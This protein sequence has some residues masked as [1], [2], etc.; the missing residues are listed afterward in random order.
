MKNS[1]AL[2]FLVLSL[3][4]F[5][6]F[7]A[8]VQDSGDTVNRRGTVADDYYAAGGTIVVDA[9]VKGDV[10][11]AGG[12]V[13]IGDNIG[14]DAIVAGG[15]LT[16]L[17]QVRD[18]VRI[19]GGTITIDANV[20]DDL[21]AAGGNIEIAPGAQVGGDA[22]VAGGNVRMN[23]TVNGNLS[24]GSGHVEIAG[25]VHGDVYVEAGE[26][27]LKEGARIDGNLTYKSPREAEISSQAVVRGKISYTEMEHYQ[28]GR[29]YVIFPL[30]TLSVAGIVLLLVFP[31]FTQAASARVSTD[32]WKNI[33]LGFA[34]LV[35]TPIAAIIMMALVVGLHV[36][37]PL[38]FIY[39]VTVL[40]AFLIG[41]FFVANYGAQKLKFDTG[42]RGRQI[43][44]LI[45]A[46]VALALLRLIPVLGGLIIFVLLVTALG[47]TVQQVYG[48]YRGG[49]NVI[50]A[51]KKKT[52]KKKKASRR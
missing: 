49:K 28:R 47:A 8:A 16:L 25:R 6:L 13:T 36:G 1:K 7:A 41:A 48:V 32:V 29:E 19:A 3:V 50:P 18:D 34:V 5:S 21:L 11:A 9:T 20:G 43:A 10:V 30:I 42:T 27:E 23:G 33:G 35:A 51:R 17:G 4:S 38:L 31:N 22:Y 45:G 26:V 40:T 52:S 39:F 46:M 14:Q 44:A 24:V 12:T 15:T 2:F 37:L